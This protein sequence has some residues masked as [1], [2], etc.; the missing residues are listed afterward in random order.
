MPLKEGHGSYNTMLDYRPL[1]SNKSEIPK[2]KSAS[3]GW[4]GLN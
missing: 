3:F 4:K 1:S 2:D